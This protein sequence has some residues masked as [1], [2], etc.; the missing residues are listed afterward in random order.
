MPKLACAF[1]TAI[2]LSVSLTACAG[3]RGANSENAGTIEDNNSAASDPTVTTDSG[4]RDAQ[5]GPT[6]EQLEVLAGWN[7]EPPIVASN[8]TDEEAL[9]LRDDWVLNN[10]SYTNPSLAQ[11]FDVAQYP[12]V[13][14]VDLHDDRVRG[15]CMQDAGFAIEDTPDGSWQFTEG[16]PDSQQDSFDLAYAICSAEYPLLP[17]IITT[18][19][20]DPAQLRV[21]YDY[22]TGYYVPCVALFGEDASDGTIPSKESFVANWGSGDS[23]WMPTGPMGLSMPDEVVSQV[24]STCPYNPPTQE[25]YG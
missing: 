10:L 23:T 24:A 2:L 15:D 7:T 19:G 8:F 13:R 9:R 6:A 21:L 12:I 18:G 17:Q 1:S 4:I 22:W 25:M 14:W 20:N 3:A 11:T 5:T 16:I